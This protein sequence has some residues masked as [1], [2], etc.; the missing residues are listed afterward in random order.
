MADLVGFG[1]YAPDVT[2]LVANVSNNIANCVPKVEGYGPLASLNEITASLPGPCVGSFFAR[3]SDGSVTIFA[4]TA[5]DLYMLD[6]T[7]FDWDIVS[8]YATPSYTAVP[9]TD[10]WQFAQFNNLVIAVQVNTPPQVFTLG[11]STAFA[12]LGGSPPQAGQIAILNQFVVLS[13]LLSAYQRV[14]WSDIQNPTEWT[15]GI[16]L[17][18]YIDLPDGGLVHNI[19]GGDYSAS[20]FQDTSIRL[21]IFTPGSATTF[22]ILR[23]STSDGIYGKYSAVTAGDQVFFHSP[24]GFKVVQAGS[25]PT[26]IGKGFVDKF[27]TDNVDQNNM[28]LFIAATNPAATQV[29]WAY[30]SVAGTAGLFDTILIYDWVLKKWTVAYISGQFLTT[31][32]KPGL[33]LAA[34]DAIAPGIIT[35]SGAADNGSGAI[36]LTLSALTAGAPPNNTDLTTENTVTVYDVTGTTEANGVWNFTIIDPT[37]IDLIGSTF[38]NAYT[39]GGQIGGA[40]A[41]LPFSLDSYGTAAQPAICAFSSTAQAAFFNGPNLAA[42]M[43]TPELNDQGTRIYIGS[44]RIMTDATTAMG[45]VG[46]R[47]N[48]QSAI[49]YTTPT[50]INQVGQCPQRIDGR[51]VRA[52]LQ[53]PAGSVWTYARGAEPLAKATGFR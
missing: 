43:E 49:K 26:P 16:G 34:L 22:E 35:I 10:N 1:T 17:S 20:I 53:I 32:A 46:W 31:F 42:T 12:D 37:H 48:A 3:N 15:A 27:F 9:G 4:A 18:D 19:Q 14:Q 29:Y 2:D 21:M 39:G 24:Q 25:Y 40:L 41:Q 28:Q 8:Q 52:R 30:K 33:T 6:A 51:Y 13:E 50:L 44:L 38:T 47:D 5:T 23:I 36:R 7:L 11:S 45:S